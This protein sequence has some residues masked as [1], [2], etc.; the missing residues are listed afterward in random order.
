MIC[1]DILKQF[2]NDMSVNNNTDDVMEH[3]FG[4]IGEQYQICELK[5]LFAGA[6][7][8]GPRSETGNDVTLY[9][10]SCKK[11]KALYYKAEY[12]PTENQRVIFEVYCAADRPALSEEEQTD[13]KVILDII[14]MHFMKWKLQSYSQNSQK[15]DYI[16]GIPNPNT[17]LAYAAQLLHKGLLV[18]YNAFYFN[19][20]R[21]GMIN[22]RFG[23]KE[24]DLILARYAK[25]VVNFLEEDERVGRLGGDNFIAIVRKERTEKF[26]DFLAGVHTYGI[27]AEKKELLTIGA[28]AG[29]LEID[30]HIKNEGLIINECAM[31]LNEARHIQKKPY[32]YVSREL[33]Q[34]VLRRRTLMDSFP[35][36]MANHEFKAFYQPKVNIND[37]TIVGAE[38]LVR[39][40]RED[41]FVSPDE[42]VPVFEQNGLV[43]Q[44]DFYILEQV[45]KDIRNWLDKGVTP[46][47]VSV[48]FSRKHLSNPNLAD[49]I[50]GIIN[51][52]EIDCKYIEIELTETVNSEEAELLSAFM[53]KMAKYNIS[54][55]IDDFGSGYA[56]LVMLRSSKIDVVKIDKSLVD[57][58][59]KADRIILS[60]MMNLASELNLDVVVEGVGTQEQLEYL[61]TVKCSVV[62]GYIFDEPLPMEQFEEKMIMKKYIKD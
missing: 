52:Y 40:Q 7:E 38:A 30:E 48:N 57:N 54:L 31:A 44:I 36:A 16:T 4:K 17:F 41:G 62:Q 27:L 26:L 39:W 18:K 49:D 1:N 34:K 14:F 50:I 5:V 20:Q 12:A 3:S 19:L 2:I 11:E 6:R 51:K 58:M 32:L 53:N 59:E 24:T 42:F 13:I 21:F 37:Y 23:L 47:R 9:R 28:V 25:E 55:T 45:C 60:S 43:C 46:V 10:H 61:K 22:K 35:N 15:L 29:I 8:G 33:K 56:S